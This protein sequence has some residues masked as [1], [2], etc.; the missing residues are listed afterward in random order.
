M[1][2]EPFLFIFFTATQVR[3]AG[4]KEAGA[5][6]VQAASEQHHSSLLSLVVSSQVEWVNDT[7]PSG[8]TLK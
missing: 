1:A 3:H 4:P 6:N 8:T 5:H 2:S 7:T